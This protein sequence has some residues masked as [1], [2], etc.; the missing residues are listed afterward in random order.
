MSIANQE[1][2]NQYG[3][4]DNP[5]YDELYGWDNHAAKESRYIDM[6]I[7]QL[8]NGEWQVYAIAPYAGDGRIY[9]FPTEEKA[10]SFCEEYG[11]YE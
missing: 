7:S 6:Q 2:D 1:Y 11:F 4:Q 10:R 9:Q 3:F 5:Q 8:S